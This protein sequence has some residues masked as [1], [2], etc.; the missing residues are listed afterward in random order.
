MVD[1]LETALSGEDASGPRTAPSRLLVLHSPSSTFFLDKKE[2][3]RLLNELDMA[4]LNPES[5]ILVVTDVEMPVDEAW[6]LL[7]TLQKSLKP[8]Q[9]WVR[10][11]F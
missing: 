6:A 11:G 3:H 10:Y 5:D 4:L 1:R 2:A 9:D 8:T 7:E